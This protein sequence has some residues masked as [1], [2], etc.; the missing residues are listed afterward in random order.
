MFELTEFIFTFYFVVSSPEMSFQEKHALCE[1]ILNLHSG[2]LQR[3]LCIVH[4]EEPLRLEKVFFLL[5]ISFNLFLSQH[6]H[7]HTLLHKH[8]LIP[9]INLKFLSLSTAK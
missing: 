4:E 8:V 9:S 2:A 6:T 7:T 5:K 3:I 1:K